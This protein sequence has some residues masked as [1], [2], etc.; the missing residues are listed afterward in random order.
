MLNPA[1]S[2]NSRLS[3]YYLQTSFLARILTVHLISSRLTVFEELLRAVGPHRY[4]WTTL[5]LI[6]DQRFGKTSVRF[7]RLLVFETIM[8]SVVF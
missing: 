7:I 8:F 5:L 3:F 4:L 6:L 2:H 1:H